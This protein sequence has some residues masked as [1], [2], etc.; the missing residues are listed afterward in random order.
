V[1]QLGRVLVTGANGHIGRRLIQRLLAEGPERARVRALVRSE[2]AAGVL[3]ALPAPARPEIAVA[4]YGDDDA[5][6]RAAAG[7]ARVAHLVG[8]LKESSTTRYRDA[9]ELA[10]GALVRAAEKAGVRRIAYLS[11]LGADPA[12]PNPCLA[13]KGRAEEILLG[14]PVPA[15]VLRVPMV[16]GPGDFASR[17]LRRQATARLVF[18]VRGGAT[19]EQPIDADDVVAA[20]LAALSRPELEHVRL[21]LAG[22]ESLSHRELVRR[23]AALFGARPRVVPVPIALARGAA[24]VLER[25]LADPPVSVAMLE[26][27]EHDDCVDARSA[28]ARLGIELTPLDATLRRCVGP[29]AESA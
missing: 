14:G 15:A 27:L 17:A 5:L 12:H 9:H 8:I 10:T 22:P 2:R 26:V 28:A 3:R 20:L 7:C 25:A 13:S 24:R 19:L 4:D 23:A 16:L 6:A 11:I 18:L 1:Q 29:E 21:D